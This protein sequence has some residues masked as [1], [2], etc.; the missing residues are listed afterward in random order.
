MVDELWKYPEH[1]TVIKMIQRALQTD[2]TLSSHALHP[3]WSQLRYIYKNRRATWLE[4][5]IRYSTLTADRC[6]KKQWIAKL[7]FTLRRIECAR[8]A[9]RRLEHL[10]IST[11]WV[12]WAGIVTWKA[13]CWPAHL[14][15][16]SMSSAKPSPDSGNSHPM[17]H[18]LVT[19]TA[20]TV[21][22]RLRTVRKSAKSAHPAP[23]PAVTF[24]VLV[25][26]T[27]FCF[28]VATASVTNVPTE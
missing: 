18:L 7:P 22:N 20:I 24:V 5:L 25:K 9:R 8:S 16:W 1:G 17:C 15:R 28:P 19:R 13:S 14:I 27:E 11:T 23:I 26:K 12:T 2:A 3:G 4:Q 6:T 21:R 10:P